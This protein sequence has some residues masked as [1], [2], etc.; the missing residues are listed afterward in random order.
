MPVDGSL[1]DWPSIAEELEG[2]VLLVGNGL[3]IN[4]WPRFDYRQLFDHAKAGGLTSLDLALFDRTPNFE[5]VLGDLNTTIR[6][7]EALGL[8]TDPVYDRYRSIQRGLGHAVRAVHLGRAQVPETTLAAIRSELLRYSWIFSTSYDL[9]VY[10]AMGC[11]G[12][13]HPFMDH[14]R[15]STLRFDPDRAQVGAGVIPVYFLHGALHLMVGGDG[16]TWKL[17]QSLV[18]TLLEQFGEPIAGDPQARPLLVTEGSA[19][20]KLR[21][22]EGNVY[23][24]HALDR[25]RGQHLPVVVFGC[26]LSRQDQHLVDVLNERPGRRVAISMLPGPKRRLAAAQAE[27]YGRLAADELVFYDATT[28][29]LGAPALRLPAG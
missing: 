22:I 12:R 4:V 23:L 3:S 19:R 1:A 13:F 10:W 25:L 7:N 11:G 20:D 27:I 29:P 2:T 28:H 15:G 8:P 26:S 21:A 5:R 17:R 14:F 6:V 9:L 24:S 16:R 18:A